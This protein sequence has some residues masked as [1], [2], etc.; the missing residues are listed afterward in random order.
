[1][2]TIRLNLCDYAVLFGYFGLILAIGLR[3]RRRMVSSSEYF[4]AG[5]SMPAVITGI[6]FV[7]ANSGALEIMGMVSLSA[8]Y[9]AR[10]SHFYWLGAIP[11]ML[12]LGLFMMPIYYVSK[13]RSVPEFLKLRYNEPTRALNALSFAILMILTSG[14]SLYAMAIILHSF[15]GWKFATSVVLAAVFVFIYVALGGLTATIYNEVLQF[16]LIV[17][18]LA[19]LIW[20]LLRDAGGLANLRA[21]MPNNLGHNWQGLHFFHPFGS[22][23][24]IFG[25]VFGLGAVLGCG[26]WCTDFLLI[27]RALAARS[28][29]AASQ[30][31]LVAA[32]IKLFFPAL[33]VLPGLAA[34]VLIPHG[35]ALRYDLALP[36]LLT[37]YY[38]H[39]LL[40]LGI[41]AMLSSFMSGM[42]GNITA[43]N[44]V[45]TYD[46]Y[47][48]YLVKAK[49]DQHYIR[50]GRA[51]TLFAT[52]ISIGTAYIA[53]R[54]NSLMDYVQLLFSFFNAP[55]FATFLLGMFTTWAT[56]QG[57]FWG[58]LAGTV[59]SLL[60]HLAYSIGL[61]PYGSDMSANFYGAIFGCTVCLIVTIGVSAFTQRKSAADLEG[62]VYSRHNS[63]ASQALS[64]LWT[65]AAVI[66]LICLALNI[67]WR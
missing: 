7:A 40:G 61:L 43:F 13:A 23:M 11:A 45:W 21:Q 49:P 52:F 50:M 31:P 32:G 39:G 16:A 10:A 51:A 56:P 29:R 54:F 64:G 27:Q 25:L 34:M 53:L 8:K 1:M 28:P 55:L 65:I 47:Q 46:I 19:P 26:Y 2:P 17:L 15:L 33:V 63:D 48:A 36:T 3:V 41:V 14:I 12:F 4:Q 5:R 60:H 59:A 9:G 18:G 22:Q 38:G 24:D 6:A 62:I 35:L 30:T 44:T 58:L 57:G 67:W 37:R 42:A 66:A 20:F